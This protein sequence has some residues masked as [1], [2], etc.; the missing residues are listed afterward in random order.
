MSSLDQLVQINISQQTAAVPQAS[1]SIPL[2]VGPTEPTSGTINA[3]TSAAGMLANGY[4]TSS[5]EYVYALELFEQPLTPTIFYV[6]Y[7]QPAVEQVDTITVNTAT[8][9]HIYEGL[10]Q[11]EQWSYTATGLDTTSTI[12]T[13][14]ASA[15]NALSN[16]TWNA[17][18]VSAVVTITS[19][20]P[21]LGFTDSQVTVDSKYTIANSTPNYGIQDDINGFIANAAG[22]AWYGMC[23]CEFTDADIEQA[24]ALIESLKKIFIAVSATSAIATSSATD[25][26]SILK[27][28]S[29]KRTGL[30]YTPESTEGKDAAWLGG[31]LPQ[32]P[33]SNNWAFKTLFG[34]TPDA[35]TANQ[36]A[37]LIGDP[38]G[39]VPGKNVNIYQTVG[40]VDITQMGTMAG[41]QF[42][43]LTVGIDWLESQLQTN[44]Y[45]ALVESAKIPYTDT[46]VG[47]LISAV[48]AAID[49]GVT[50][51]LIDGSSPISI[52]APTV[53]SVPQNQRAN[54][55][56]PTISFSCRLAGA[57]NAVVV[58]GTVTV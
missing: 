9:G 41:G 33:G 53:L 57:F 10:I 11:G 6:G 26:G 32:V 13:A 20:V 52:S 36:Q 15:I 45:T 37:I 4:T 51:G 12:A 18:A 19:T 8:S 23:G 22:N 34:C 56:A 58:S 38:V 14:I 16:P 27:G 50:N 49:Q 30:V 21:G 25:V 40:G 54:R 28:K 1:F 44:I 55:I 2:V 29:Y 42:I 48:K 24:A 17:V 46:G 43:D 5:P 35:L 7:R 47:V 31:Q 3:Y 39:G